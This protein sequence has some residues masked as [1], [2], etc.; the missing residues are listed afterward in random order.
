MKVTFGV[1]SHNNGGIS[2]VQSTVK[3][4]K[5]SDEEWESAAEDAKNK[6]AEIE[7]KRLSAFVGAPYRGTYSISFV[8]KSWVDFES[9]APTDLG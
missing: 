8:M 2:L 6:V 4:N 5:P 1:Y 9:R 3:G 7:D